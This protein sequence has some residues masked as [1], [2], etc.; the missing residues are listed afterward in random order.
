MIE[1]NH[2]KTEQ[3]I[4]MTRKFLNEQINTSRSIVEQNIGIIRYCENLLEKAELPEE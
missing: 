1:E 4:K 2:K 3:K